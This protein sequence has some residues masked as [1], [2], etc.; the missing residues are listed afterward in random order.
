MVASADARL[1]AEWIR[2]LDAPNQSFGTRTVSA[3][4]TDSTGDGPNLL[5]DDVSDA[6][7]ADVVAMRPPA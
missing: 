2:G 4:H 6:V 5:P 7:C 3:S 1:E